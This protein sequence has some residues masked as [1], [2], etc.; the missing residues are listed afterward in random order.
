[1]AATIAIE[2][3]CGTFDGTVHGHNGYYA[4]DF[5]ATSSTTSADSAGSW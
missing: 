4:G 2:D 1:M 3:E 5:S